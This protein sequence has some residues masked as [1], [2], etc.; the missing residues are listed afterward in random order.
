MP[1]PISTR[2]SSSIRGRAR[3]NDRGFAWRNKGDADRAIQDFELAI[4][5]DPNYALAYFNRANAFFDKKDL[6]RAIVDYDQAIKLEANFA[7][8]YNN[9]GLIWDDKRDY[10]RAIKDFDQAIR[11]NPERCDGLQQPRIFLSQ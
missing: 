11:L 9:R 10:D 6:D 7:A 5:L 4:K 3:P 1:S 2:R 8:A